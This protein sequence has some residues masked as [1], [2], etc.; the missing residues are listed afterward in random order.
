VLAQPPLHAE[1]I[2]E[3]LYKPAKH[4]PLLR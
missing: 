4:A 1:R 2:H 3:V